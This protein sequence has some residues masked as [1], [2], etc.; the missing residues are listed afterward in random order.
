MTQITEVVYANG[1]LKPSGKLNLD[2]QQHVRIIVQP[3]EAEPIEAG[4]DRRSALARL[5][6]G[7]ASMQFSSEGPLPGREELHERP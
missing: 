5:R 4:V 6:A 2:E 1:V 7:I 3:I